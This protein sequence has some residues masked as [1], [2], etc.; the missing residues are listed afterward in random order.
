MGNLV[1]QDAA[2]AAGYLNNDNPI[3]TSLPKLKGRVSAG[4][5][6]KTYSLVSYLNYISSYK[7]QVDRLVLIMTTIRNLFST[8]DSFVT[9]DVSFLWNVSRGSEHRV[10]RDELAR[11]QATSG[12][13]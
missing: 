8:I 1:L 10:L 12:E 2:D 4:Y 9:W 3:A 11:H 6:W 7:D 5:H 13:Y